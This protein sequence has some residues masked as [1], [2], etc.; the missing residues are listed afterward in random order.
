MTRQL[1]GRR[2]IRGQCP[3]SQGWGPWLL[4]LAVAV[5]GCTFGDKEE[6]PPS[7]ESDSPEPSEPSEPLESETP[8]ADGALPVAGSFVVDANNTGAGVRFAVHGV[9]R[10]P[11]GSVLDY[12]VTALEPRAGEGADPDIDLDFFG[13]GNAPNVNL[14]DPGAEAVYRPLAEE[15][16]G[17]VCTF[18]YDAG[19]EAGV[20]D[21]HQAAFPDLPEEL[22]EVTVEFGNGPLVQDVPVSP[23]GQVATASEET[24]LA[25]P[26]Q[27]LPVAGSTEKFVYPV[28]TPSG[29]RPEEQPLRID[30]NEV[31]AGSAG[32]T[33]VWTVSATR[34]GAGLVE[35]ALP[36]TDS[37]LAPIT[38]Q[39]VVGSW[40]ASGP[41]LRPAGEA[42]A[43]VLR[44][45]FS[46]VRGKAGNT[47][48]GV[49]R[50]DW[51]QCL[52]TNYQ[53]F[54]DGVDTLGES[55]TFVTH[56]PPLAEST[57]S[58]DVVFPDDS[59]PPVT[60]VDITDAA[61]G[62]SA[63][64]DP[65]LGEPADAEVDTWTVSSDELTRDPFAADEWPTPVPDQKSMGLVGPVVD[66]LLVKQT[67]PAAQ[68]EERQDEVEITL[69]S[70]VSFQPDSARLTAQA[71]RASRPSPN[72]STT[73][74]PRAARSP[75]TGTSRAPTRAHRPSRCDSRS[76]GPRRCWPSWNA[77][78]TSTSGSRRL[79]TG[80]G[81]PW[82][83][84]T[85]R[86]TA[87][88]TV[89]SW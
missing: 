76:A 15:Q 57:S 36:V 8:V 67:L 31:L 49:T 25:A 11:G 54:G 77:R 38:V 75:S 26:A 84:T 24:D 44:S 34:A 30:I 19:L 65:T 45:W 81:T 66:D 58:V 32:T 89:G 10:V 18:V 69:D 35:H 29:D 82:H 2:R 48:T 14:I 86:P 70:T 59:L 51:K 27:E 17:C 7:S 78:S 28:A 72:R 43:P 60:D 1:G 12:S 40:A 71:R 41:G 85:P 3:G 42:G 61:S 39:A 62:T 68:R 22:S 47:F 52:C 23:E 5:S 79:V 21:L 37:E 46:T 73:A 4:L 53:F 63:L 13:L 80:Q 64:S 88:S 87:G 20:T 50:E 74:P 83:P 55:R 56:L 9:R 16:G 6:P 33:L